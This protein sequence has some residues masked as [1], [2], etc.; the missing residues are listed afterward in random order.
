MV[1]SSY[2]FFRET[3]IRELH[4][5]AMQVDL[6]ADLGIAAYAFGALLGGDF[7]Q[8]Y[9][10]RHVFLICEGL[11]FTGAV[12]CALA[13][14]AVIFEI[15]FALQGFATG[16]LLVAALP[17]VIRDFPPRRLPFTAAV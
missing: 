1:A 16:L 15:G 11:F 12:V 7:V 2:P 6:A 10:Q 8:R 4:M 14:N 13:H 17:P 3:L 5:S 9:R